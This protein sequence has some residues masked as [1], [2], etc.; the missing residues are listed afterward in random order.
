[1]E[2]FAGSLDFR[3]LGPVA[4]GTVEVGKRSV[5]SKTA[6]SNRRVVLKYPRLTHLRG[7]CSGNP[8]ADTS[9]VFQISTANPGWEFGYRTDRVH[10]HEPEM[11]FLQAGDTCKS[12]NVHSSSQSSTPNGKY[13]TQT[14]SVRAARTWA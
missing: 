7:R 11:D 13:R 2:I 5:K 10:T 14:Q 6:K 3:E 8:S 9:A 4:L 12:R 1:M